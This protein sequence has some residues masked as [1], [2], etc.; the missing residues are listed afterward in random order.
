MFR[1]KLFRRL[2]LTYIVVIFSCMILY[3]A[4]V[5]YEDHKV[6]QIQIEHDSEVLLDRVASCV[7]NRIES[8]QNIVQNLNYS[9]TLKQLY[10]SYR[11]DVPLDSNA[12]LGI[13]NE[14][15]NTI[16]IGGLSVYKDVI[17]VDG[18]STAYSSGG[19]I[20]LD[21]VFEQQPTVFPY[22]VVST[23][24][25]VFGFSNKRYS[26]N[27]EFLLYCDAY[28]YRTGAEIGTICIMLDRKNL[29]D[30]IQ[31]LVKDGYG[32]QIL[33]GDA[34]LAQ[35]G[36][37]REAS[38][39]R[40]S[41]LITNLQYRVSV[42]KNAGVKGRGTFVG[43][44]VSIVLVSAFF[45]VLAYVASKKYYAPIDLMEQMVEGDCKP[46]TTTTDEM[47]NIIQGI[48]KLIGEKNRYRDKMYTIV[49]Y[50]KTGMIHS[51][52]TGNMASESVRVLS[53]EAYWDLVKPYFVVAVIN[54]AYD[55]EFKYSDDKQRQDLKKIL[56]AMTETFSSDEVHVVSYMRD[57]Y[58]IFLI[59]NFEGELDEDDLFFRIHKYLENLL[60]K[61][62]IHITLGVDVQRDDIGELKDA[63]EG[64]MKALDG[65]LTDGRGEVYFLE[66]SRGKPMEY[67]FPSDFRDR[68]KSILLHHDRIEVHV[69]LYDIYR[70]NWDL[71]GSPEMY[72]ALL[73]EFYLAVSKV[74][75]EITGRS[76]EH[77]SIEKY[78]GLAT[79]QDIFD[80]YDA[81]LLSV[82][83]TLEEHAKQAE[84]DSRLEEEIIS[85]IETNYCDPELSLQSLTVKYNVSNKYLSLLCKDHF[86]MTY[87]QYI[88]NRRIRKAVE[89]LKENRYSLTEIS[90]MCG[91]TNQLT[92][93]RNFK[94]ITGRNPSDFED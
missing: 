12:L 29:A 74:L 40:T 17:F 10:M 82:I 83:D 22:V 25:D 87:L 92:F 15:A 44:M 16:A 60:D 53:Q 72:R 73:D 27:K 45:V 79:L 59:V 91:Y 21:H 65:I 1:S 6:R 63:C 9:T 35:A 49:P 81:A 90:V 3:M 54:I 71:A 80:Y 93:R 88:Q 8:A 2:F 64:A 48:Q 37:W 26:F 55:D 32:V 14:M 18:R 51:A 68:L 13:Q 56:N 61:M 86:G 46:E 84:M 23:V 76:T 4:F 28:T 36:E 38:C 33:Y 75:R 31:R 11:L 62:Y 19:V 39:E 66:P 34:V 78:D 20:V 58:N 50:A 41:G 47:Q 5:I 52:I 85:Y 7:E 77:L 94:S 70:T 69:L 42:P 24:N 43:I 30:D 89:L 57:I 67:Y